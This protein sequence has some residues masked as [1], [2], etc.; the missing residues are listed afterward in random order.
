MVS[1][2]RNTSLEE[3]RTARDTRIGQ[4]PRQFPRCEAPW[5]NLSHQ[6]VCGQVPYHPVNEFGVC[7]GRGCELFGAQGIRR[8]R[9]G[10]E[11]VQLDPYAD[12]A[13]KA[14]LSNGLTSVLG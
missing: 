2:L 5:S 7:A 11:Y 14:A 9:K 6:P 1:H 13:E 12:E 4:E 3:G 8:V 10:F